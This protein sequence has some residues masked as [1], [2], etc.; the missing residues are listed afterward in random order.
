MNES[1][2]TFEKCQALWGKAKNKEAGKPIAN[3]TRLFYDSHNDSFRIRLHKTDILI[4][5]NDNCYHYDNG[6]YFTMTTKD[7]F[8]TYGPISI[9]TEKGLWYVGESIP[10]FNGMIINKEGRIL[11]SENSSKDMKEKNRK[12]TKMISK[13]IKG[14]VKDIEEN[15]LEEPSLGDYWPCVI[16]IT[17]KIQPGKI[18]ENECM[19]FDH[20]ISHME[21]NYFVPSLLYKAI[22]E[23]GYSNPRVIWMVISNSPKSHVP[24]ILRWYLNRRRHYLLKYV[25]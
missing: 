22:L 6:E 19:G 4:I 14:F 15:G 12:L 11:N 24:N 5:T 10:Y 17:D 13:Y 18:K 16:S 20:Y 7:R 25:K 8:N 9:W 23:K 21:E 1:K 3:N 2:L